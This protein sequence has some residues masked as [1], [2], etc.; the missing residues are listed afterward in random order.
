[1][2][3]TINQIKTFYNNHPLKKELERAQKLY[4]LIYDFKYNPEE[5]DFSKLEVKLNYNRLNSLRQRLSKDIHFRFKDFE[6]YLNTNSLYHKFNL[7]KVV[8]FTKY[9]IYYSVQIGLN[10]ATS[11]CI[12]NPLD[13][14]DEIYLHEYFN[15]ISEVPEIVHK[16]ALKSFFFGRGTGKYATMQIENNLPKRAVLEKINDDK[17]YKT[18]QYHDTD[19]DEFCFYATLKSLKRNL[20]LIFNESN[21]MFF[22]TTSVNRIGQANKGKEPKHVYKFDT[23]MID[24]SGD[25]DEVE[26]QLFNQYNQQSQNTIL[27]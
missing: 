2:T 6:R 17:M 5:S 8:L 11:I 25:F 12:K 22:I 26:S 24:T 23:S 7:P 9:D 19:Q 4:S 27:L 20:G 1:M 16:E 21:S 13:S 15:H 10:G 14:A 18:S 3:T